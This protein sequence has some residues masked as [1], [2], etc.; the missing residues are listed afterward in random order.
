MKREARLW[1]LVREN[2]KRPTDRMTRVENLVSD[3][4]PDVNACFGGADVWIELKAPR[5]P[6]RAAT[7]LLGGAGNHPLLTSQINWFLSQQQAGGVAFILV[8]TDHELFLVEGT[9]YAR[10]VNEWCTDQFRKSSLLCYGLPL[11]QDHWA[12][13]RKCIMCAISNRRLNA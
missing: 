4:I 11:K 2:L 13:M 8:G 6:K 10:E 1:A 7:A 12:M 3:G 9:L 5:E